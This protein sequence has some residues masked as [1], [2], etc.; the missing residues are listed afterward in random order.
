MKIH[1][2]LLTIAILNALNIWNLISIYST[3]SNRDSVGI[4]MRDILESLCQPGWSMFLS[5]CLI[6]FGIAL[7]TDTATSSLSDILPTK[8]VNLLAWI[9]FGAGSLALSTSLTVNFLK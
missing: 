8:F 4:D 9:A 5:F 6:I 7:T 1:K 3:T 2:A